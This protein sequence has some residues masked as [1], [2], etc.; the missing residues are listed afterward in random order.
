MNNPKDIWDDKQLLC[1]LKVKK[2][3]LVSEGLPENT[4]LSPAMIENLVFK[5][6]FLWFPG[7]FLLG[8]CLLCLVYFLFLK[9]RISA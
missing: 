8:F 6:S 3:A 7:T 2:Q 5:D 9:K 4:Q 1:L